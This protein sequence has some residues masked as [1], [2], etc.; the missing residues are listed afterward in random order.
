MCNVSAKSAASPAIP[1]R[2]F[3]ALRQAG[4]L[5]L[6]THARPDGDALGSIL[7]LHRCARAAGKQCRMAVPD[8]LPRRY[9]FLF[10]QAGLEAALDTPLFITSRE[11]AAGHLAEL[12]AWADLVVVLDA[13]APQQLEPAAES[14]RNIPHKLAV[15]DHHVECEEL[16]PCTWRDVSA[17]ATGVMVVELAE[18]L[19]WAMDA[20]A[21][22]AA[23]AAFAADTGWFRH[24]NTDARALAAAAR[25]CA[26][27]GSPEQLYAR[28][29][30][31]DR[32]ERIRLLAVALGSLELHA[33][34]RLA[35]MTLTRADF[36]RVGAGRDEAEEFVNE[37]LRISS[38]EVAILLSEQPDG[39]IRA[40][41]RSR[42]AV[43]VAAIARAFGGGG[44]ARA[45]GCRLAMDIPT[46][47]RN[48]IAAATAAMC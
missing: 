15:I 29:Y 40:S 39:V 35:V 11:Q 19:G 24:A 31:C 16:S 5:V 23:L 2:L 48:L 46:A 33:A 10:Q 28:L 34:G 44:H 21:V 17:A 30:Q 20:P 38:V 32:P 14:L 42:Q 45:A 13:S 27:G 25:L 47:R 3:Q 36:D 37:A 7:A 8:M 12:V 41:L 43:D 22:Q 4:R 26:A 6:L 1:A 18:A 9:A